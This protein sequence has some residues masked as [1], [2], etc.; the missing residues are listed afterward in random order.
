MKIPVP[1][2]TYMR[3]MASDLFVI[4]GIGAMTTGAWMLSPAAG[5]ILLG[6]FT[7]MVGVGI[8]R[9]QDDS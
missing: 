8:A 3:N 6:I 1:A 7:V 2:I 9:S 5:L 4:G